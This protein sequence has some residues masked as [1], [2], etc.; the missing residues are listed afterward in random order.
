MSVSYLPK[1]PL[2]MVV[3]LKFQDTDRGLSPMAW[4]G[5]VMFWPSRTLSFRTERSN[6]AGTAV[7]LKI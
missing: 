7:V 4:Q 5:K 6:R 1:V 2:P 3:F